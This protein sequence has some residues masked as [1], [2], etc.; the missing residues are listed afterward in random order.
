MIILNKKT[1]TLPVLWWT[2]GAVGPAVA[3]HLY[4]DYY[5]AMSD[6]ALGIRS[7]LTPDGVHPSRAGYRVIE[8]LTKAAIRAA[9]RRR[10][11]PH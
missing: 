8:P 3:G 11:H 5:E 9:L 7:D 4:V 1:Q 6:G 10:T 2:F